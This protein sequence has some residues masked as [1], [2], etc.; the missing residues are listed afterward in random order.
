[1][2]QR[3]LVK[4]LLRF[5][6]GT[7]QNS[8][9]RLYNVTRTHLVLTSGKL[10]LQK[11]YLAMIIKTEQ[12]AQMVRLQPCSLNFNT[13]LKGRLHFDQLNKA[14]AASIASAAGV[15]D[16]YFSEKIVFAKRPWALG[17][18]VVLWQNWQN[19][20][21]GRQNLFMFKIQ[22]LLGFKFKQNPATPF[23]R[24]GLHKKM[25]P[26]SKLELERALAQCLARTTQA[27]TQSYDKPDKAQKIAKTYF[28][29]NRHVN[30]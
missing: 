3:L 18:S 17:A 29:C 11:T 21:H 14:S 9:Q 5:T 30:F 28:Y 4:R 24:L 20:Q 26:Y 2:E 6:D 13:P 23:T 15:F 27:Q 16:V 1:M 22:K 10:V 8:A 25:Q 7:A 19:C 12:V